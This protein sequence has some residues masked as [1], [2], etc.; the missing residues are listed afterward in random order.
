[1]IGPDSPLATY[2]LVPAPDAERET[3]RADF[4]GGK[5]M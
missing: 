5:T 1:M 2:G 4:D 3:Y